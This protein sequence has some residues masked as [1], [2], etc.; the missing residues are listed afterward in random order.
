[1]LFR[2]VSQSRYVLIVWGGRSGNG[3]PVIKVNGASRIIP[4]DFWDAVSKK[5][6]ELKTTPV[7]VIEAYIKSGYDFQ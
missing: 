3:L 5:A 4:V 7:K 1:M 2:S 6:N